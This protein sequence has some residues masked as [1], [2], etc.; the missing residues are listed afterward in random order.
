MLGIYIGEFRGGSKVGYNRRE[1]AQP[2]HTER[3]LMMHGGHLVSCATVDLLIDCWSFHEFYMFAPL[4][5]LMG[6]EGLDH[7]LK[8]D[9][10]FVQLSKLEDGGVCFGFSSFQNRMRN[11]YD[12]SMVLVYLPSNSQ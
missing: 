11:T 10:D 12:A 6:L 1:D 5:G 3:F 7:F 4:Q 8:K 2:H 9:A